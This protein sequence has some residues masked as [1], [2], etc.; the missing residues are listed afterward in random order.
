MAAIPEAGRPLARLAV[1]GAVLGVLAQAGCTT[2]PT[3]PWPAKPAETPA[4]VS[5]MWMNRVASAPDPARG[6]AANHGLAGKVYLWS[7]QDHGHPLMAE[8]RLVVEM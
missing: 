8:G 2:L 7:V 5:T 3:A 6:G 4:R 1:W